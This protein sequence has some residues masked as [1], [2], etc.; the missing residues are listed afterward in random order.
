M[1]VLRRLNPVFILLL[2]VA[3]LGLRLAIPAGYMPV[4]DEHGLRVQICT[5]AGTTWVE[6]DP[7][8]SG[9]DQPRDPCP[10]G[11]AM[12]AA[13][14]APPLPVLADAPAYAEPVR[15]GL[16]PARLVAARSLRPPARGPPAFA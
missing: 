12:G 15:S 4:A 9:Q 6:L 8:T 2:L 16:V 13:L 7:G 5:G 10:Y 11:L 3:T 14:D 1:S